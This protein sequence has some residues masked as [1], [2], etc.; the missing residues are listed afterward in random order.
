MV[1]GGL[2]VHVVDDAV[3]AADFVDDAVAVDAQDVPGNW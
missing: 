1:P 2:D 3:D